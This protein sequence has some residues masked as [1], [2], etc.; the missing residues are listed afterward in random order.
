MGEDHI[1]MEMASLFGT[2][3]RFGIL[4]HDVNNIDKHLLAAFRRRFE[5]I[6]MSPFRRISSAFTQFQRTFYGFANSSP[7]QPQSFDSGRISMKG[8]NH[9]TR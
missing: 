8:K 7:R 1:A 2:H 5:L 3:I 4:F 9:G 6:S